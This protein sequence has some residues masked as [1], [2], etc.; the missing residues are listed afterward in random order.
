MKP[1][2]LPAARRGEPICTRDGQVVKFLLHTPELPIQYKVLALIS[3]RNRV[4][5]FT[6]SG[7]FV[8]TGKEHKLD[9]FMADKPK[10]KRQ[11][12][13]GVGLKTCDDA[14]TWHL[15]TDAYDT[16]DRANKN[17]TEP[18]ITIPIEIEVEQ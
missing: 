13:I 8:G 3:G 18:H 5:D 10:V 14:G 9:L 7:R 6:E 15:T 11:L 17:M 1:F 16:E 4:S 2:D 12:W